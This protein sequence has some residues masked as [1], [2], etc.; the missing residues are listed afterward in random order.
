MREHY[1]ETKL[2]DFLECDLG[3][4]CDM[5]RKRKVSNLINR[6]HQC[7]ESETQLFKWNLEKKI[8]HILNNEE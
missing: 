2:T 5:E 8:C 3:S 7:V 4:L 6:I 1:V